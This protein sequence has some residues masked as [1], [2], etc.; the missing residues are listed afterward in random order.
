MICSSF[1][2][3]SKMLYNLSTMSFY[4]TF[5]KIRLRR[6][7]SA[8]TFFIRRSQRP[9]RYSISLVSKQAYIAKRATPE[10]PIS[11][12]T[13]IF[14]R[15]MGLPCAHR[16]APLLMNHQ[17]IPLSEIHQFWRAGLGNELSEYLPILDP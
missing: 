14:T 13:N 12:C 15:T 2:S 5:L 9:S 3:E 11:K 8:P 16:I 10:A 17:T 7:I 4:L 1:S 6:L